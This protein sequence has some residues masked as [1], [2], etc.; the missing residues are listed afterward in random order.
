MLDFKIT[1]QNSITEE[2][3]KY[4]I[5]INSLKFFIHDY[6]INQTVLEKLGINT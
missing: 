1:T 6:A 2:V 4:H 3:S 5:L